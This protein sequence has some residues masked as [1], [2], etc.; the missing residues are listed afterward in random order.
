VTQLKNAVDNVAN[1]SAAAT[2]SFA[3]T[4]S[5]D[6]Y[7]SQDIRNIVKNTIEKSVTSETVNKII[8]SVYNA[9]TMKVSNVFM[10]PCGYSLWSD[11]LKLPIPEYV[12]NKCDTKKVCSIDQ[13]VAIKAVSQQVANMVSAAIQNDAILGSL[14]QKATSESSAKAAGP[15]EAFGN[16][17]SGLVGSFGKLLGGGS[18]MTIVIIIVAVVFLFM[19]MKK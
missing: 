2:T 19:M 16:A 6:S 12:I 8:N 14:T 4:S 11:T 13:V 15:I 9:Q 10:D 17:I 18:G 3:A 5:T 1:T 7:T